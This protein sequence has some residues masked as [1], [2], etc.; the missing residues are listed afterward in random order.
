[1][2]NSID[3]AITRIQY[4]ALASELSSTDRALKSAP[5]Y[6]VENEEPLPCCISYLGGG[7]FNAANASLHR[8]FPAINVEFHFSRVNLKQAYQ[9]I[10][11]VALS[12]PARLAG[13]PTLNG[14]V[15]TIQ[16]NSDNPIP[17]TVRPFVWREKSQTSS[18]FVTQCLMFTVPIKLLKTPQSTA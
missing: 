8:N 3:S 7:E 5:D 6:P 16:M 15:E 2:T 9:D 1:M 4:I 17:Y 10:N 13:D 18:A 11:A 12:F 14:A